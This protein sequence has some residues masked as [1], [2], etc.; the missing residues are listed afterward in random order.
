MSHCR[1]D[2]KSAAAS[3]THLK[4][5]RQHLVD[6]PPRG[7]SELAIELRDDHVAPPHI[8]LRCCGLQVKSSYQVGHYEIQSHPRK[9]KTNATPQTAGKRNQEFVHLLQISQFHIALIL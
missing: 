7:D 5:T 8:L 3:M 1:L 2:G 9:V 6:S 4:P